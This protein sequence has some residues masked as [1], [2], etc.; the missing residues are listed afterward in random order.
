MTMEP[1][2]IFDTIGKWW[3]Q[4]WENDGYNNQWM[5][6]WENMPDVFSPWLLLPTFESVFCQPQAADFCTD[7][8]QQVITVMRNMATIKLWILLCGGF[9]SHGGT[10]KLLVFVRENPT[11]MDGLGVPLFQE[12]PMC[13]ETGVPFL[14]HWLRFDIVIP[15]TDII[16]VN[17]IKGES[18]AGIIIWVWLQKIEAVSR[19]CLSQRL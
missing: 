15:P 8:E 18:T 4:P 7:W 10:Q 9:H 1:P 6:F 17:Y 14:S 13:S 3:K 19:S 5:K 2:H 16:I 11:K 12:T